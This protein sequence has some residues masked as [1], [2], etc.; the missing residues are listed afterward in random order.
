MYGSDARYSKSL[1][2]LDLVTNDRVQPDF[3]ELYVSV[4]IPIPGTN[5]LDVKGGKVPGP[6]VGGDI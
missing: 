1:G 5:G 2:F 3:P 6:D 4:H